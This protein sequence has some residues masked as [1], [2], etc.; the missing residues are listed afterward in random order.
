MGQYYVIVNLDKGEFL[1]P[2][3]F[4]DGIKLMEFG[5]STDGTLL[6]LTTLLSNGNGRGGGD[7]FSSKYRRAEGRWFRER[8]RF[9]EGKRKTE[10]RFPSPEKHNNPLIGSWAGDRIVI[11]GDYGDERKF[12]T[13]EQI[14]Q[15][16]D[17]YRKE[18][19]KDRQKYME[20]NTNLHHYAEEF[21]KD[22]SEDVLAMLL[23]A[24]EISKESQE[25]IEMFND[26]RKRIKA[27]KPD[28]ILTVGK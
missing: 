26:A 5:H 9:D 23:D 7:I 14:K 17:K 18:Q 16:Q 1:N 12:L 19:P 4:G 22:I 3:C 15:F 28:M 24:G 6:A 21:F 10:P 25:Q 2:H 8:K 11:A 27:L 13:E 20:D